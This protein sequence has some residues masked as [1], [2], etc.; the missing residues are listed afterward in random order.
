MKK[1][2]A[3]LLLVLP[4]LL[5]TAFAWGSKADKTYAKVKQKLTEQLYADAAEQFDSVSDYEDASLLAM[6]CRAK[7]AAGME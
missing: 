4:P 2:L 5:G 6:Y 1:R 3:A 7:D